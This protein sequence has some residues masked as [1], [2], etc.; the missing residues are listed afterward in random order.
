MEM[1]ARC[2]PSDL[3]LGTCV[4]VRINYRRAI[5]S[6]RPLN[7]CSSLSCVCVLRAALCNVSPGNIS[8]INISKLHGCNIAVIHKIITMLPK[9][10]I[11]QAIIFN[12]LHLYSGC[13]VNFKVCVDFYSAMRQQL[14]MKIAKTYPLPPLC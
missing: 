10:L 9:V 4:C 2:I 5:A 13:S 12:Y 1:L 11:K 8:A 6:E 14:A 3:N 7:P